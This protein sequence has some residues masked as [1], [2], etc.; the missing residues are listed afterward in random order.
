MTDKIGPSSPEGIPPL[1]LIAEDMWELM[2][3][4]DELR[5]ERERL[6]SDVAMLDDAVRNQAIR[7]RIHKDEIEQL[8][9]ALER[10]EVMAEPAGYGEQS[11]AQIRATAREALGRDKEC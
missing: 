2:A 8:R 9:A 11:K 4:R 1:R 3:E 10:I 6:R 5:A 7:E